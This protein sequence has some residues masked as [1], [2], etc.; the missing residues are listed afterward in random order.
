MGAN[1]PPLVRGSSK[2]ASAFGGTTPQPLVRGNSETA[3][4]RLTP[5]V[6][7]QLV[8]RTSSDPQPA[9]QI[10]SHGNSDVVIQEPRPVPAGQYTGHRPDRVQWKLG[11]EG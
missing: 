2:T 7:V 3:F 5:Q 6:P 1:A 11:S 4:G 9:A 8:P 10:I